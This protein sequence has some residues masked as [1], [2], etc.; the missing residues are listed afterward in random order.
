[1]VSSEREEQRGS[2]AV[3]SFSIECEELLCILIVRFFW[4]SQLNQCSIKLLIPSWCAYWW[5]YLNFF[6]KEKYSRN[7]LFRR[8]EINSISV[9]NYFP[10]D[11][12]PAARDLIFATHFLMQKLLFHGWI[13]LC[14]LVIKDHWQK[15]MCGNWILGIALKLWT[16]RKCAPFLLLFII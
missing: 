7:N 14:N 12:H 2:K 11:Q 13:L 16:T 4:S 8:G 3:D 6:K 15:R 10:F 5:N 1:M 9:I